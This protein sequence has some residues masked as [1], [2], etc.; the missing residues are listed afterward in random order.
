[1]SS[2][3]GKEWYNYLGQISTVIKKTLPSKYKPPPENAFRYF[4]Y[5]IATAK[6]FE[7]SMMGVIVA[8]VLL[9]CFNVYYSSTE[10]RNGWTE[11]QRIADYVFTAIYI[12]ELII[13]FIA[14][15]PRCFKNP[16]FYLDFVIVVV[17]IIGSLIV[18]LLSSLSNVYILTG[19]ASLCLDRILHYLRQ[20]R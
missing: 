9:L 16:W 4:F 18:F 8:N 20:H 3:Q 13:N 19:R 1:V 14:F 6:W 7:Y 11:T 2:A 5:R 15:V 17:S 10:P 12:V